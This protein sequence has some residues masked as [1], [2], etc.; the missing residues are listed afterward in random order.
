M[1]EIHS[2]VPVSRNLQVVLIRS[3]FFGELLMQ[4]PFSEQLEDLNNRVHIL[5][6]GECGDMSFVPLHLTIPYFGLIML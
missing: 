5:I 1:S 4:C 6:G 3:N 2:D